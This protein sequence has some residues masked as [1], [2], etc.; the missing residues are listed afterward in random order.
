MEFS[1]QEYC[2]GLLFSSPG[3]LPD[4][5]IE[6]GS[7]ALKAHSLPSEPPGFAMTTTLVLSTR[8]Q[9]WEALWHLTYELNQRQREGKAKGMGCTHSECTPSPEAGVSQAGYWFE[10]WDWRGKSRKN[11]SVQRAYCLVEMADNFITIW[12]PHSSVSKESAC[13]AGVMGSIPELGKSPVERNGNLL[14][15]YCLENPM[16]RGAWWATVHGVTK[17]WTWLSDFHFHWSLGDSRSSHLMITI[18]T[19]KLTEF[20]VK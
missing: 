12:Y 11:V 17:S 2:S 4:P 19:L 7:P 6:P 1:R 13:N 9:Y 14:Q 10:L 3:D 18:I 20:T 5:G 16:V 8:I 15:Y